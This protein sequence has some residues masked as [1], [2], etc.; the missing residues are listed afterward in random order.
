MCDALQAEPT[1]IAP[2]SKKPS[3]CKA[4]DQDRLF[5]KG[6]KSVNMQTWP[7]SEGSAQG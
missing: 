1:C 6:N 4:E 2:P 3:S 7:T 5:S